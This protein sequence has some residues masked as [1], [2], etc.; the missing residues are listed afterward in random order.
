VSLQGEELEALEVK[1]HH[2]HYNRHHSRAK[3]PSHLFHVA[4]AMQN[5]QK[6]LSLQAHHSRA[7][8][9]SKMSFLLTNRL[10]QVKWHDRFAP[11]N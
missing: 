6:P 4:I 9:P 1:E 10:P 2:H 8:D 11:T 3:L 5:L 7:R